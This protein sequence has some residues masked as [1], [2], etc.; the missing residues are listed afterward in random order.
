M[1]SP[2]NAYTRNLFKLTGLLS[3]GAEG[4]VQ[5]AVQW[6][7]HSYKVSQRSKRNPTPLTLLSETFRLPTIVPTYQTV[8]FT[9]FSNSRQ[10]VCLLW[11]TQSKQQCLSKRPHARTLH[12]SSRDG[13]VKIR[14]SL[15]HGMDTHHLWALL[16]H[17]IL[18]SHKELYSSHSSR[19]EN[20]LF[21]VDARLRAAGSVTYNQ[22]IV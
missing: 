20:Y 9:V 15:V 6:L 10:I 17:S 16:C 7:H 14:P 8:Y 2:A 18:W 11:T 1:R 13:R 19:L 3:V 4:Q 22:K 12:S 5:L 21:H